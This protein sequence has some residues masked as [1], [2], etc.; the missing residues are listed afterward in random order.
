MLAS[1]AI[2]LAGAA[3]LY[4]HAEKSHEQATDRAETQQEART[5]ARQIQAGA[6]R[7][8]L[9][10]LQDLLVD[11]QLTVQRGGRIVF[12]GRLLAGH[13][14]ELRAQ[15][16]F[17]GGVVRIVDYSS[18]GGSITMSLV[19]ITAGLLVLVIL[20]AIFTATAVTR[21]VRVPVQRAI[22]TAERVSRGELGARMGSSGPEELV[23]LGRAFDDM[24]TRLQ[25]ADRDQRQ[26]LADVAHEIATPVNAISGFALALADGAA[27]S[28]GQRAEAK[29]VIEAETRRLRDMLTDLRE[30]TR[31][32]LTEGVRPAL[33]QLG[34]FTEGL[35]ARFAPA[36]AAAQV[37]LTLSVRTGEI[38]TDA[39]LLE[40]IA[41]NL[42]SN[43]IRYTSAGGQVE[44]LVFQRRDNLVFAV[45]DDGIGIAR[46]HHQR[47]FERLYRVDSTRD[48]ATG[49][50]GLGLAIVHRAAESL[51][52]HIELDSTPGQGSEFR[53]V[54]PAGDKALRAAAQ[55]EQDTTD[56]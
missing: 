37:K 44:I 15:A 10:A 29:A 36:A 30:L 50:T 3:L 23:K 17:P 33:V 40:T 38:V 22:D 42:L 24:A 20:A 31:L 21:A 18:P 1:A 41:A 26:F 47:I 49:G 2:G 51:G 19:L 34:P 9:A 45:R 6:D 27:Q 35:V 28:R 7:T 39:R 43:A 5:I 48:R 55:H 8:D 4:R 16:T 52:G 56:Q 46:E 13:D 14:V 25:R 54:L 53:L 32:D 11:D 12:A